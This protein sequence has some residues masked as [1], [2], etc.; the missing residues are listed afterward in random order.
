MLIVTIRNIYDVITAPL[1]KMY[2][3]LLFN[4]VTFK[5]LMFKCNN[6]SWTLCTFVVSFWESNWFTFANSSSLICIISYVTNYNAPGN[7]TPDVFLWCKVRN[8]W[9]K[10]S[11]IRRH[12][13]LRSC[14]SA[15]VTSFVASLAHSWNLTCACGFNCNSWDLSCGDLILWLWW[16]Y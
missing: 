4:Y 12:L 11:R 6:A 5:T 8:L 3:R 9:C 10:L 1:A 2:F 7:R 14:V 15:T 13:H 16:Q